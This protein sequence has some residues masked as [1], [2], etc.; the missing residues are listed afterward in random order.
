MA[1]RV[2]VSV[3]MDRVYARAN[4]WNKRV[5]NAAIETDKDAGLFYK[6]HRVED[7]VVGPRID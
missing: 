3:L 5:A 4:T 6:I 2:A 1:V 7:A